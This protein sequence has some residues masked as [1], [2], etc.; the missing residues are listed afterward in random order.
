M[1]F[2]SKCNFHAVHGGTYLR[3]SV[4]VADETMVGWTGATNIH[5]TKL[6]NKPTAIGI[7]LKTLCDAQTRVMCSLEFVESKEEQGHKRFADLGRAAA[8]MLRLTEPWHNE[9][10][11]I[12]IADAWFGGLPTSFA[13]MQKGLYSVVVNVK[14]HT[15]FFHRLVGGCSGSSQQAR[16]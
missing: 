11:H 5:I 3:G 10:P 6:P 16:A 12:L 15:K 13:L 1:G 14:T 2:G 8:C 7:C 9:R 4:V